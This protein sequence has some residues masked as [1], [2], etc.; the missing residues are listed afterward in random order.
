MSSKELALRAVTLLTI[1][2]L[3]L[4]DLAFINAHKGGSWEFAFSS[5]VSII[6]TAALPFVV[7][8]RQSWPAVAVGTW[9]AVLAALGGVAGSM[10]ASCDIAMRPFIWQFVLFLVPVGVLATQPYLLPILAVVGGLLGI[11]IAAGYRRVKRRLPRWI[12]I[13]GPVAAVLT[14]CIIY[15][16]AIA[17]GAHPVE[18]NCVL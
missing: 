9:I 5:V 3:A 8:R 15:G 12:W 14:A 11:G 13:F 4:A 6:L 10:Y 2:G 1:V 18:G 7:F 17:H 16:V